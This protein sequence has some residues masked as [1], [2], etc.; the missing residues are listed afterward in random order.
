[1]LWR[2]SWDIFINKLETN[3]SFLHC[4]LVIP[5]CLC[6]W[7]ALTCVCEGLGLIL[8][9]VICGP[10]R[11]WAWDLVGALSS[12]LPGWLL[13]AHVTSEYL[14]LPGAPM[15][16]HEMRI[17]FPAGTASYGHNGCEDTPQVARKGL[18]PF[19]L[20]SGRL[21]RA[22]RESGASAGEGPVCPSDQVVLV[23]HRGHFRPAS[24]GWPCQAVYY[25]VLK[26]AVIGGHSATNCKE[27]V[28]TLP[29]SWR[30]RP[31]ALETG[32]QVEYYLLWY[33]GRSGVTPK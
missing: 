9:A 18:A 4:I 6:P 29:V 24:L 19:F 2:E 7:K 22:L 20:K 33:Y 17:H 30:L 26:E 1:M 12:H 23:G 8:E 15:A 14:F 10:W 21:A 25:K 28:T 3:R 11:P 27:T 5:S 13:S 16:Q 31:G 32:K